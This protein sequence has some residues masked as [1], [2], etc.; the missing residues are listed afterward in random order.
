MRGGPAALLIR[1]NW[2]AQAATAS[3][4]RVE[5]VLAMVIGRKSQGEPANPSGE[6]EPA[7]V[8]PGMAKPAS[9]ASKTKATRS[10]SESTHDARKSE[11]Q[12]MH[13]CGVKP[14]L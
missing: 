7:K 9:G 4:P 1:A 13:R 8:A 14:H 6:R 5:P 3:R 12:R 11:P 2:P 10:Q